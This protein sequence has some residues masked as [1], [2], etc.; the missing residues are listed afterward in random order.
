V[1]DPLLPQAIG[2]QALRVAR[3]GLAFVVVAFIVG[4]APSAASAATCSD[5]SNQ[6]AGQRA[7]DTRDGDGDGIYCESLPCPCLKPGQVSTP[8]STPTPTRRRPSDRPRLGRSIPLAPVRKHNGCHVRGPLP[9]ASCTPGARYQYATKTK[10]CAPG[11]ARAVRN[12]STAT[13][14]AVYAAYGIDIHFN[15]ATGEVDHLVSLELGGS[16]SQANLFPEAATPAPGSHEK[17]R[18]ENRL[19]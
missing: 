14:D 2:P 13:K 15:G 3:A 6:A 1:S 17:D 19:H 11:Y 16:N 4:W 9:D 12:V 5:Y 7:A 10:V 8:G 18:L